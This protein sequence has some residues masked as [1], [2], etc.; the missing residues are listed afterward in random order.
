MTE[1][2]AEPVWPQHTGRLTLRPLTEADAEAVHAF[3]SLPEVVAYLSHGVLTLEQV[4]MR[5]RA[6]MARGHPGVERPL[7]P[8]AVVERASGRV[9]GDAMISLRPAGCIA[10]EGTREREGTLGYIV[11]PSVQGRGLGTELVGRLLEIAFDQLGLRRVTAEVFADNV[12][13]ARVLR[14][15]GLRE[16][17]H[18]VAAVLGHEGRWLDDLTFAMLREEWL[19]QGGGV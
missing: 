15:L 16:E 4:R 13:S 9:V 12:P 11:H 1:D 7:I 5:I 17:R 8:L 10:P 3:R 18:A 6:R 2:L 14:R 19:E